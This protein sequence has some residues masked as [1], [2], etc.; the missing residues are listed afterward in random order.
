MLFSQQNDNWQPS[1]Y[2]DYEEARPLLGA[3][4]IINDNNR[5]IAVK[6]YSVYLRETLSWL[7]TM[8]IIKEEVNIDALPLVKQG[9]LVTFIYT[10]LLK[11]FNPVYQFLSESD[12]NINSLRTGPPLDIFSPEAQQ[13]LRKSDKTIFRFFID[14]EDSDPFL[15]KEKAEKIG[16][17]IE[18][19]L[20][21]CGEDDIN[22]RRTRMSQMLEIKTYNFSRT[23]FS[24]IKSR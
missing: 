12:E 10:S 16:K 13:L 2:L 17:D 20:K 22:C 21:D 11:T 19:E 24:R 5:D 3:S 1:E 8:N 14:W 15:L 6:V 9:L 23:D 18:L 7:N 4:V